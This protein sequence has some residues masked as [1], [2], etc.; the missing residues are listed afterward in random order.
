MCPGCT[1]SACR[2]SGCQAQRADFAFAV[3]AGLVLATL[4]AET[5]WRLIH[6]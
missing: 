3:V 5:V 6:G 2:R 1:N 4:A